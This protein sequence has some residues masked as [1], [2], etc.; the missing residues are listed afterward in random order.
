MAF[1]DNL[2]IEAIEREIRGVGKAQLNQTI[3]ANEYYENVTE[4]VGGRASQIVAQD[5]YGLPNTREQFLTLTSGTKTIACKTNF[6]VFAPFA[7]GDEVALAGF[8]TGGNNI[9]GFITAKTDNDT[10][11]LGD[12]TFIGDDT[13]TGTERVRKRATTQQVAAVDAIIAAAAVFKAQYDVI[14]NVL[15]TQADRIGDLRKI[16]GPNT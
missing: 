8:T 11:V 2:R 9:N 6:A 12:S 1:E 13:A 3:A 15:V 7:V 16:V 4:W 14:V 5:W 10:I